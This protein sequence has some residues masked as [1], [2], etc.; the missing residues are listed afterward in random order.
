[1][2]DVVEV[3]PVWMDGSDSEYSWIS[4]WLTFTFKAP[5]R[6]RYDHDVTWGVSRQLNDLPNFVA[7]ATKDAS[8]AQ[9]NLSDPASS[10]TAKRFLDV[11]AV[12]EV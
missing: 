6:G 7:A 2:T 3:E 11:I 1:V 10:D 12:K 8:P 5:M 9:V 4:V